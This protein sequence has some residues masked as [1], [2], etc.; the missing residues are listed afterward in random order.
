MIL[1]SIIGTYYHY[2]LNRRK[3]CEPQRFLNRG[4][5]V[6]GSAEYWQRILTDATINLTEAYLFPPPGTYLFIRQH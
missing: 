5:V 1:R 3:E 6:Q 2:H 4:M